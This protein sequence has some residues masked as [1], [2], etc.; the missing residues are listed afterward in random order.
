[1]NNSRAK[2]IRK[3]IY[4]DISP[5]LLGRRYVRDPKSGQTISTGLRRAFQLAKREYKRNK[6]LP[7]ILSS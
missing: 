7:T 1:M 2:Q 5:S 6:R 3:L 4:G